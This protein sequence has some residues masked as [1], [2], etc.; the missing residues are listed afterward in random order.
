MNI[1]PIITFANAEI[2]QGEKVVL[3][4]VSFSIHQGEMVYLIGH[5][6]SGKS[7]LLKT[8]YCDLPL[9]SG[10]AIVAD[11][12]LE[13]I[14]RNEIPYLRRELGIVF[15]DFQLLTDRNVYDNLLFA[16]KATDWDDKTEIEKRI[17]EVLEK[18]GLAESVYKMPNQLSGGEQ[19]RVTIA[20]ALLNDPQ[21]V[22]ADEPT[23][24]LDP[25]ASATVMTIF[26][27]IIKNGTAVF[28][29]THNY[30]L[31]EN[32]PGRVLCC[33]QGKMHEMFEEQQDIPETF[34]KSSDFE[35][36]SESAEHELNN[37]SHL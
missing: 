12:H 5:T 3:S 24:N 15:Q 26:K 1:N 28:M 29:A 10:T 2:C 21:I 30:T 19:Q 17:F 31:I 23:G 16:L 25:E 7:S 18:V 36:Y 33:Q 14:K 9:K 8:I 37:E 11:Y 6:A 4:E 22:I 34:K 32:F 27:E 20:R 13:S 35:P